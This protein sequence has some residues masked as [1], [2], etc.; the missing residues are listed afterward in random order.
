MTVF[1][2]PAGGRKWKTTPCARFYSR[3]PNGHHRVVYTVDE[4]T[5]TATIFSAWI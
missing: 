5:K 1:I 3:R 4:A 2:S